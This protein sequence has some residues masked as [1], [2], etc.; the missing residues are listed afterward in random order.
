MRIY[1]IFVLYFIFSA[2]VLY[3]QKAFRDSVDVRMQKIAAEGP[4][5]LKM[6]LS[7]EIGMYLQKLPFG[8]YATLENVKYLGYKPGGDGSVEMFSWSVPLNKDWGYYHFFKFK[9]RSKGTLIKSLPGE[10]GP[11]PPYL[12]YDIIP[13]KS[14]KNTCYL[15]LGW[16]ETAKTNRKG[17][18]VVFFDGRG[19]A[20]FRRKLLKS[21]NSSSAFL[22]FEYSRDAVMT[23]KHDP[24]KSRIIFDNLSPSEE[25]FREY[26]MFYG[27]DGVINALRLKRGIWWLEKDVKL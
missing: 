24:K 16:G 26:F 4:D 2:P 3:G 21:G 23:L 10:D 19:R 18:F 22:T 13:F 1:R 15:L 7:E 27:P 12:F 17:V 11:V 6:L 20:D 5:S 8:S 9:D 25:R 14:D